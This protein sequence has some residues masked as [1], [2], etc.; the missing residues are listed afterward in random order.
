M[1]LGLRFWGPKAAP[2]HIEWG[3]GPKAAPYHIEWGWGPKA[4]PYNIQ[5]NVAF[6]AC[7]R[8]VIV[9]EGTWQ[10]WTEH[11]WAGLLGAVDDGR[12]NGGGC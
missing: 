12:G 11:L 4:A 1:A 10:W 2:Y 6:Y 9:N 7:P 3:W 8:V 5:G